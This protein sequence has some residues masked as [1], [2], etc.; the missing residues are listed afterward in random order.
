MKE[1]AIDTIWI[2]FDLD[3]TFGGDEG[4]FGGEKENAFDDLDKHSHESI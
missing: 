2:W 4:A 3:G 1:G